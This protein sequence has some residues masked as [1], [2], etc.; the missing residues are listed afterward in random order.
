LNGI[1]VRI[2]E[3]GI[4]EILSR[5]GVQSRLDTCDAFKLC[6]AGDDG[7]GERPLDKVAADNR[8]DKKR[9]RCLAS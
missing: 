5:T 4:G 8:R 9:R 7:I 2:V 6:E 3:R 1:D